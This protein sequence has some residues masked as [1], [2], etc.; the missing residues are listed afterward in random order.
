MY[1]YTTY[2]FLNAINTNFYKFY[3]KFNDVHFLKL[4]KKHIKLSIV[5]SKQIL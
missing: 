4:Y 3:K 1:K 2:I 5:E